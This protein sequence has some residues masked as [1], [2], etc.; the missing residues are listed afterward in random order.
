MP[1]ITITIDVPEGVD[2]NVEQDTVASQPTAA[3]DADEVERYF[4]HYLSDNGRRLY[5]AAA[6]LEQH[7]GAGYTL[8][9]IAAS[10]S[11]DY[12]SAQSFHRTSGRSG[13]R[14]KDDTGTEPPVQL[15]GIAYEWSEDDH[16]MRSRYELPAGVA[17]IVAQL[18]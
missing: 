14:W 1:T 9:D 6:L 16:G 2:V 18:G 17:D 4:R 11:I 8:S 5:R 12:P 13:R 7:R 3:A 10:L 15:I